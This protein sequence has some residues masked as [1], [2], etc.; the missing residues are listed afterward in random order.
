[1]RYVVI[2]LATFAATL[3]AQVRREGNRVKILATGPE[4]SGTRILTAM[5]EQAGA[6]AVHRSQP[7]GD[8]WIDLQAMCDDFDHVV[9]I[10]RGALAHE[11]S[12]QTCSVSTSDEQAHE[13]RQRALRH[14]A[15]ILGRSNVTLVTYESLSSEHERNHLLSSL[16]LQPV[17]IEWVD[18]NVK[19]YW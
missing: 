2:T 18:G 15:P 14:I 16:G 4:S 3:R 13:R 8:D 11:R 12:L 1:M 5:L 10:I 9:V 7:E 17:D 19:H 6:E